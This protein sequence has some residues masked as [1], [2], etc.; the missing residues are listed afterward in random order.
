MSTERRIIVVIRGSLVARLPGDSRRIGH[1]QLARMDRALEDPS[2]P[3]ALSVAQ[4]P[5]APSVAIAPTLS[6]VSVSGISR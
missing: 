2:E 4:V 6:A 3:V 1:Q 5:L